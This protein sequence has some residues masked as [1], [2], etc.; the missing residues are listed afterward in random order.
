MYFLRFYG[1]ALNITFLV[2]FSENRNFIGHKT[3]N[4]WIIEIKGKIERY[5]KFMNDI[6][7]KDYQKQYDAK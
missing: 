1:N 6:K 3:K 2:K 5:N 4:K 7:S